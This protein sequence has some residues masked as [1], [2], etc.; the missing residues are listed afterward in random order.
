MHAAS[1]VGRRLRLETHGFKLCEAG[2][3]REDGMVSAVGVR[4]I[5][6]LGWGLNPTVDPSAAKLMLG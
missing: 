1:E 3:E 4:R 2:C 6:E 5:V